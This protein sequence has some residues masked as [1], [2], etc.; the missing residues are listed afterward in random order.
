MTPVHTF[1]EDL[2]LD[3]GYL[4]LLGGQEITAN[5]FASI[6]DIAKSKKV[7]ITLDLLNKLHL[8]IQTY[9]PPSTSSVTNRCLQILFV[10]S[11]TSH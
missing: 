11:A 10:E 8:A 1:A 7:D 5:P 4:M 3:V 6:G 2:A 9:T